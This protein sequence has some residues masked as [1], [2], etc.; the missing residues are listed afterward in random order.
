MENLQKDRIIKL[1][2]GSDEDRAI[3][4]E[5]IKELRLDVTPSE[6]ESMFKDNYMHVYE[7]FKTE[8]KDVYLKNKDDKTW[9]KLNI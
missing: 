2:L 5:I 6:L 1:I 7:V 9:Y 3:A 8:K 4:N